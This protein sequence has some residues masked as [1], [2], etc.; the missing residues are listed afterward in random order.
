MDTWDGF[1]LTLLQVSMTHGPAQEL[2]VSPL[3]FQPVKS[4][5]DSVGQRDGSSRSTTGLA[6]THDHLEEQLEPS[7]KPSMAPEPAQPAQ[8]STCTPANPNIGREE[9]RR[10]SCAGPR[11]GF[12]LGAALQ[13]PIF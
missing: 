10:H 13:T 12:G 8:P 3:L 1:G 9:Q 11:W 5:S 4:N 2:L 7:R 6:G